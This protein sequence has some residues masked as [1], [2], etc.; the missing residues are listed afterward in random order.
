MNCPNC[1]EE[2]EEGSIFC[3]GCGEKIN[4]DDFKECPDC[5]TSNKSDAIYCNSCGF[6]FTVPQKTDLHEISR[7]PELVLGIIGA[8]LGFLV[9]FIALFFSAFAESAARVFI[10]LVFFS[11]LGLVSTLFVK[12]YHEVGGVG[13]V[14]SG[15]CLLITG[16]TLGIISSFLFAIG[17]LLA[18]FRK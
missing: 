6:N 1:N 15:I 4:K 5:G 7:T 9:S 17:G 8:V 18:L 10:C 3:P 13:M 12:K 16:G 11:I 14:I 2:L